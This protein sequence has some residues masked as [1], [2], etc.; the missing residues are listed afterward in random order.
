MN[1]NCT[2]TCKAAPRRS[3]NLERD[4]LRADFLRCCKEEGWTLPARWL[5][6]HR[7]SELFE[8]ITR[9]SEYY[10]TRSELALLTGA[11]Q[12]LLEMIGAGRMLVEFGAGG[13]A[14]TPALIE[15]INPAR[16]VPIDVSGDYLRE[17]STVIAQRFP[18]LEVTPIDAD[19]NEAVPLPYCPRRLPI[20]GF[21]AGSTIGNLAPMEATDLLR[22]MGETLGGDA[23]LLIGMDRVKPLDALIPA[24]DDAQ[25]V[26]AAFT[27]N[28]L[29]RVNRELGVEIPIEKFRHEARW[30]EHRSRIELH[31]VAHKDVAFII[32]DEEI[33]LARGET[34]HIENSHKYRFEEARMLLRCGGWDPIASWSAP[35]DWYTLFLAE[36]D[37]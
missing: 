23:L 34:L 32:D 15:A 13:A 12:E 19:F 9:L 33:R 6:D 5:Y 20:V 8:Q 28:V 16:Y 3:F 7:G 25:G 30:N 21:F 2:T 36:R 22:R 14:K 18:S 1:V 17:S 26:S 37:H 35:D 31:L 11:A 10:P 29:R 24:Y 27:L 4:A